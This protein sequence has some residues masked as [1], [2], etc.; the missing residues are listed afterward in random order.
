MKLLQ[1]T[2]TTTRTLRTAIDTNFAHLQQFALVDEEADPLTAA[3]PIVT[4]MPVQLQDDGG[5]DGGDDDANGDMS[6]ALRSAMERALAAVKYAKAKRNNNDEKE[7]SIDDPIDDVHNDNDNDDNDDV[8]VVEEDD[9]LTRAR[10]ETEAIHREFNQ[11]EDEI[12]SREIQIAR[13]RAEIDSLHARRREL[14]PTVFQFEST[15]GSWH[16]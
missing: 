14:A 10:R 4:E 15:T 1:N 3:I 13:L 12:N 8:V 11:L 7:P 2:T 6:D 9:Q 16:S 5:N